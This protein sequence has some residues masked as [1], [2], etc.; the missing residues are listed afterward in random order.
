MYVRFIIYSPG[1]HLRAILTPV[2]ISQTY[3][4]KS[5]FA[6]VYFKEHFYA[7]L[8]TLK[9]SFCQDTGVFNIYLKTFY[10]KIKDALKQ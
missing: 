9:V 7:L 3:I 5:R 1:K 2:F 10:A 8:K 6:V 4:V